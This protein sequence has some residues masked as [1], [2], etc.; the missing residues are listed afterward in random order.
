MQSTEASRL[1]GRESYLDLVEEIEGVL[2][3]HVLDVWFPACVDAASGGFWSDFTRDWKQ[4][5]SDGKFLVFQGRM[6]WTAAQVAM[7]RPDLREQFLAYTRHGVDFLDRVMWDKDHGGLFWGLDEKGRITPEFTDGKHLYGIG[8]GLYAAAAAYQAT[9]DP[10]ALDLAQRA[11]RWVEAHARDTR[12][13]GYFEWFTRDGQVQQPREVDMV[14]VQQ[15]PRAALPVGYK[16]M[17]AHIHLLEAY[18]QLYLVWK[19]PVLQQRLEELLELV[20]HRV[21]V[22]PG[23]MNLYF[24]YDWRVVPDQDSYGHDVET[25]Y[26]LLEAAEVLGREHDP[27]VERMARMLVDHALAYGWDDVHGGFYYEGSAWGKP[28]H[29]HKVWWAE[30]EG[31]NALLLMH[32]KYGTQ[33]Q[34]YWEAFLRQWQFIKEHQIDHECGGLYSEVEADGKVKDARKSEI[35]KAAYHDGRALLNVTES[36][37]RLAGE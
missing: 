34:R 35:W 26:L 23:A 31:L 14:R 22:E 32:T 6:T 15:V 10:K 20:L 27:K 7:R 30:V 13:G 33:T 17:N 8:F 21:C 18:T 2:R 12:H 11:F 5:P 16:S 4:A 9:R 28:T 25:A 1:A 36:L 24:T 19:D 37:H 29:R 3:Q